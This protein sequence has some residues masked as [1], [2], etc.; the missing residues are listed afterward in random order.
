MTQQPLDYS[1]PAAAGGRGI[2]VACWAVILGIV[3]AIAVGHTLADRATAAAA[4]T[5]AAAA[6]PGLDV[7]L[8]GRM[9]VTVAASP[10]TTDALRQQLRDTLNGLA[11]RPVDRLALVTV[12]RELSG[13]KAAGQLLAA[14]ARAVGTVD[15]PRLRADAAALRA[16]YAADSPAAL[17]PAQRAA[18][19]HDLGYFGRLAA[20]QGGRAA[21]PAV[22]APARAA[23]LAEAHR[24]TVVTTAVTIA[25][26]GTFAVGFV[27]LAVGI[28]LFALGT[29]RFALVPAVAIEPPGR[30]VWLEAFA[31]WLVAYV[32]FGYG[33]ARLPVHLPVLADELMLAAVTVAIAVGWPAWRAG[34]SLGDVRRALGLHV[35]R[36]VAVEMACGL[37]GYVAGLP[38]LA[39]GVLLTWLLTKLAG[40]HPSHP[41]T[42]EIGEGMS[43][44]HVAGLLVAAAVL[45]PVLEE[46]MFRGALYGHLRRRHR[47]WWSAAVVA[48]LFAAVHPQ[49]WSAIPLLGSIA[50]VLAALREWRGSLVAS[51]TAHAINNGVLLAVLSAALG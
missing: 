27:L 19:A 16:L 28:V 40:T 26:F 2:T 29:L 34:M 20:T 6:G 14:D 13:A 38:V 32:V 10:S 12:V 9:A 7:L 25:G 11:V 23:L 50:L 46:T 22:D 5:S 4:P 41:I 17:T 48:V 15:S 31:L 8:A 24:T 1:P 35:G 43:P 42:Q 37:A 45:A 21:D 39:I 33:L 44:G 47:A 49:G 3:G 51:M 36:G 30:P 18:L